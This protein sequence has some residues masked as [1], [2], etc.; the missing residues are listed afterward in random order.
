MIFSLFSNDDMTLKND[1]FSE[2][3]FSSGSG[4]PC[5]K[6]VSSRNSCSNVCKHQTNLSVPRR[7]HSSTSKFTWVRVFTSNEQTSNLIYTI[8]FV[9]ST[10]KLTLNT[11]ENPF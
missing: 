3:S 9:N 8:E 11:F 1:S 2:I 10:S 5:V 6:N 4:K 7:I